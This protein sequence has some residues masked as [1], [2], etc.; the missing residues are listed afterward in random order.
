MFNLLHEFRNFDKDRAD[1]NDL[2][3]LCAF[4]SGL[5]KEYET[6]NVEEPDFI[7]ATLKSL[8]RTIRARVAD[9][10]AARLKQVESL[11]EAGKSPTEKRTDLLAEQKELRAELAEV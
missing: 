7:D 4:G 10:K 11:L 5:R 1:L 6:L 2:I 3:A 9:S 8:K